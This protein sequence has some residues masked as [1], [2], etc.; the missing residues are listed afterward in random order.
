M[1][2]GE[3]KVT[4]EIILSGVGK[5]FKNVRGLFYTRE[6]TPIRAGLGVNG[7]ADLIGFV[8]VKITPDMVGRTVPIFA[9]IEVKKTGG[10]IQEN[11]NDWVDAVRRNGGIACVAKNTETVKKVIDEWKNKA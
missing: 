11:Q 3:T 6:G 4:H 5:F 2:D 10:T 1:A 7:A 8:P 9:S